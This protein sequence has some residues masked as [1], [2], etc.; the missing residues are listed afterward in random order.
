[1]KAGAEISFATAN[2][3][4]NWAAQLSL[5]LDK[6]LVSRFIAQ[7]SGSMIRAS[8]VG[9]KTLIRKK[10]K[11]KVQ[12]C[13]HLEREVPGPGLRQEAVSLAEALHDQALNV[14]HLEKE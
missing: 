13:T 1:M 6:L 14:V 2:R 3:L 8:S 4:L 12:V 9:Q 10:L 5:N 7:G 11:I